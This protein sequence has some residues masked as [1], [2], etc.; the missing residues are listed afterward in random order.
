VKVTVAFAAPTGRIGRVALEKACKT[1][2]SGEGAKRARVGIVVVEGSELRRL[3]REYLGSDEDTDVITFPLGEPGEIEA[4]IYISADAAREQ[5]R[6]YRAPVVEEFM[7]LAIHGALH[8]CGYSDATPLER[9]AMKDKEDKY[10][11]IA[12][13][14]LRTRS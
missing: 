13:R 6:E 14:K 4:E 11:Q 7:R 8:A 9:K 1:A 10:L 12:F 3:H 5:A 2:L